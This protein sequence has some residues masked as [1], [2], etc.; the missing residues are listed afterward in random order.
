MRH[1]RLSKKDRKRQASG[2][3]LRGTLLLRNSGIIRTCVEL[4]EGYGAVV[5]AIQNHNGYMQ[6][7]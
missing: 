5:V 4:E 7:K 3:L 2:D 1:V 6:N